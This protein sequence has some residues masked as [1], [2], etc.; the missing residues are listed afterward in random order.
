VPGVV[1]EGINRAPDLEALGAFDE[2]AP[3]GAAAKF[4]V[5]YDFEPRTL[6]KFQNLQNAFVLYLLERGVSNAAVL[7]LLEG[8]PQSGRPQETADVIGTKRRT[9]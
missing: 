5:G 4:A 6:L 8:L 2:T 1:A 3:V 7:V 9:A